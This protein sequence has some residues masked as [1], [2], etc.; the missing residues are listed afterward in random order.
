MKS[1]LIGRWALSGIV[2]DLD[3][4]GREIF[5][6]NIF[7]KVR[8]HVIKMEGNN[9]TINGLHY[10]IN[11]LEKGVVAEPQ[12]WNQSDTIKFTKGDRILTRFACHIPLLLILKSD[13][14]AKGIQ[15]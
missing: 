8:L 2:F 11:G 5:V 4:A 1:R 6:K 15:A 12:I 3:M 7:G 13:A 9:V 10:Q 14:Y